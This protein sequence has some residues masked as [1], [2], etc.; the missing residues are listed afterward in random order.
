MLC[1]AKCNC[2]H[3]LIG[4][5]LNEWNETVKFSGENQFISVPKLYCF[6]DPQ[7]S[8]PSV[9]LHRVRVTFFS[10]TIE[11]R[12]TLKLVRD[13]LITYGQTSMRLK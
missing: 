7:D 1:L 3:Q 11:C 9:E 5:Y 8:I 2:D 4:H 13:L 12:F 6:H 10:Q